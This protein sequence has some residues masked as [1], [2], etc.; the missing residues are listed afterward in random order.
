MSTLA[1]APAPALPRRLPRPGRLLGAVRARWHEPP[2][3]ATTVT[4]A[5]ARYDVAAV[6]EPR[7]L[8]MG[9]RSDNV[10][11]ATSGGEVVLKR[12]P[13]RKVVDAIVHEHS[14]TNRLHTRGFPVAPMWRTRTGTTWAVV[15]GRCFGVTERVSGVSLGSCFLT[16]QDRSRLF[17]EAGRLLAHFHDELEGFRPAGRHHLGLRARDLRSV[18]TC[19]ADLDELRRTRPESGPNET[20]RWLLDHSDWMAD[21]LAELDERLAGC[22]LRT[23]VIHGDFGLHNLTFGT[24]AEPTVHDLELA[25]LE[26]LLLDLV[27]VLS[28]SPVRYGRIFLAGYDDVH[29]VTAEDV[30]VLPD[31]W[32]H[33]RLSGA[34]RSWANHRQLGGDARLE[35]ARRRVGEVARVAREGVAAWV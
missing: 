18:E 19:R 2:I 29:R 3:A 33:Y 23:G 10:V 27:V 12:Y 32:Q 16:R 31:L 1:T 26:R 25:R 4:E 20:E 8:P 15:D 9:W 17:R 24:H 35:T 22:R 5:L 7:P 30:E 28:R 11:V 21:L 14:V 6:G 34:V 13:S